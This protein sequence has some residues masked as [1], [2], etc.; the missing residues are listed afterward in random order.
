MPASS[1]HKYSKILAFPDTCYELI[2]NLL[3]SVELFYAYISIHTIGVHINCTIKPV[4][5]QVILHKYGL[6]LNFIFIRATHFW[7]LGLSERSEYVLQFNSIFAISA[8]NAYLLRISANTLGLAPL[9]YLNPNA[10]LIISGKYKLSPSLVRYPACF[11]N[12]SSCA[13]S[14]FSS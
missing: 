2:I 13:L 1:K 3:Q 7:K 14:K 5:L 12:F 9:S 4:F 8:S 6:F 10:C 11:I